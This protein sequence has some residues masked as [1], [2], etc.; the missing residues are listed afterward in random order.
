M[1]ING[2]VTSGWRAENNMQ[3]RRSLN[4][5]AVSSNMTVPRVCTHMLTLPAV[6]PLRSAV[7]EMT[8]EPSGSCET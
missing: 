1:N 3:V 6:F 8:A 4:F 2:T 5:L 7:C